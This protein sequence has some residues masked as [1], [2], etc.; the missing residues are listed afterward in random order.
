MERPVYILAQSFN[1]APVQSKSQFVN[2]MNRFFLGVD[3][4][5]LLGT[6]ISPFH[7]LNSLVDNFLKPLCSK[8]CI[9][10]S[11]NLD[12]KDVIVP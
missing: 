2:E 5:V 1:V 6:N 4:G 11:D 3:S 10:N 7:L 12:L 8:G 9:H